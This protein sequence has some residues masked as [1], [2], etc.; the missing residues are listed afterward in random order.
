MSPR[1]KL[2]TLLSVG[3]LAGAL[4][5]CARGGT[6]IVATFEDVGDLQT[7]GS[8][9]VA[10]VRVGQIE[11]ISLTKDF[12]ARVRLNLNPG[13][14]VPRDSNALLRTTSLLGEKFVELR[15]NGEPSAGPHFRDGD[16]IP[17]SKV[18]DSAGARV[19]GRTS[20]YRAR[21]G[22]GNGHSHAGRDRAPKP[23]AGRGPV[24]R[25]L[26]DEL[27]TISGDARQPH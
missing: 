19:C 9:Q 27:A 22:G 21:I 11:K 17:A 1:G 2:A 13:V 24:L 10:D 12:R 4:S 26:V 18:R 23:L 6:T 16:V 14:K 25:S 20:S 5:G 3:A 7:R 15:P 8:V